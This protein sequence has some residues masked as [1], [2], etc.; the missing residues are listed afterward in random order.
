MNNFLAWGLLATLALPARADIVDS[1]Y[2]QVGGQGIFG[3][4]V[5]VQGSSLGV[6]GHF[7]ATSATLT[8]TGAQA[9]TLT[10]S[11]GIHMVNG[12]LKINSGAMVEWPD[13]TTSVSAGGGG[14]AVLNATQSFTGANTFQNI[15]FGSAGSARVIDTMQDAVWAISIDG[16]SQSSGC[17]VVV[18]ANGLGAD[19]SIVFTSTN[20]N[21]TRAN[22]DGVFG[23]LLESC[24]PGSICRVGTRGFYRV[25]ANP[26]GIADGH[27]DMLSTTRCAVQANSAD[28]GQTVGYVLTSGAIG[29]SAWHWIYLKN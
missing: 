6:A 16:A 21:Q 13:G 7:S 9:F 26:S 24:A 25:Q 29:A 3:G 14:N 27:T 8:A 17:V 20:T 10:T 11:S 2:L 1:G 22:A 4:S 28:D 15:A 19:A 5:T 23:V 12:K 18:K